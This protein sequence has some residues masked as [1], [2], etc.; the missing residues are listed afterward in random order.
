MQSPYLD[1]P[2]KAFP[3]P[4]KKILH[5]DENEALTHI[6][7]GEVIGGH[8][9]PWGSNYTFLLWIAVEENQCIRAIYKPRDGEK[10]LRD[11]ER[12]KE[13]CFLLDILLYLSPRSR[14]EI[15]VDLH[16][17]I[18][19]YLSTHYIIPLLIYLSTHYIIPLLIYLY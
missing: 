9:M 17:Y 14:S 11:L 5:L 4:E 10:P 15:A 19:L 7:N 3:L 8:T 6:T 2:R 18:L 13:V 16:C 12:Q 1:D